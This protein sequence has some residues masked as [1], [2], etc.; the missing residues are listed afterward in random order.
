MTAALIAALVFLAVLVQTLSG[1]GFAIIVMPLA[2]LVLGVRTAAP[3]IAMTGLTAYAINVIRY[4]R[5]I[6]LGELASLAVA[7][8]LGVPV[9]IWLLSNVSESLVR[10]VL[11]GVLVAFALYAL[12]RPATRRLESKFWAYPA[13]FLAGC[14]GGAYNAPGPPAI[15]YGSL[16]HWPKDEFRAV[17]QTLFFCNAALVVAS[18]VVAGNITSGVLTIFAWALPALL[19]GI[20][21]GALLDR[22]VDQK[23]FRTLVTVMILGLGMVLLFGLGK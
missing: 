8:A 12:L 2:T 13:G 18:H 21:A 17:L 4:R 3:L 11:G 5:A 16:R 15:V 14:L 9:G 7:S 22:V 19:L 1:F 23:R 10:Q 6:N 20:L